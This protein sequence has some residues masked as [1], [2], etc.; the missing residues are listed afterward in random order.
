[1]SNPSLNTAELVDQLAQLLDI[2]IA[3]D[4]RPGVVA[5]FERTMAIAQQVLEFPLPDE[6]EVAPVFQPLPPTETES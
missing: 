6:I 4:H 3:P 2:P 1:M 5:N